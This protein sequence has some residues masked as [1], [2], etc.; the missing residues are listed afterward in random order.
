MT[1]GYVPKLGSPSGSHLAFQSQFFGSADVRSIATTPIEYIGAEE[2][3][4]AQH[5]SGFFYRHQERTYLV[6]ARHAITGLDAFTDKP[7]SSTGYLPT[8]VA[9]YPSRTADDLTG[10]VV[11][12]HSPE[13]VEV[14]NGDGE[15]LW[16]ED[17]AFAALRTDIACVE[18]TSARANAIRCVNEVFDE[19]LLANVGVDCFV[20]GFSSASYHHPF[21]P[22]WR[23]GSIAYEP[24]S[25]VDDKPIFLVDAM[26]SAGMSGSAIFQRW[27]GPAPVLNHGA[28]E[29]DI[30][31]IVSTR[32]IGVYGGR[33][34]NKAELGQIGYG[35]YA[36]RI[37]AILSSA[38]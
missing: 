12:P 9:V 11:T 32:L 30:K 33:L 27:H 38:T 1:Q 2:Q 17:P 7:I 24:L 34:G 26:T 22:I 10:N 21:F 13:I 29:V 6:S 3:K 19:Q 23:R 35:W 28:L 4:L 31:K 20:V 15:Q 37:P 5:A 14:R 18:M 25:P 8:K 36:N 16:L